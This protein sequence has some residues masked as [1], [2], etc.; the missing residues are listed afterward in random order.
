MKYI[1]HF[2]TALVILI[3]LNTFAQT[4]ANIIIHKT[5]DYSDIPSFFT[6][7]E[8]ISMDQF[9]DWFLENFKTSINYEIIGIENDKQGMIHYRCQ[10]K[11][12]GT[13]LH[14]GIFILHTKNNII[15]SINGNIFSNYSIVNNQ[16]LQESAALNQALQYVDAEIYKWQL[17]EEEKLI[18]YIKDNP[19]A[20][21]YP[22]GE[23]ILIPSTQK[24]TEFILCWE[25]N[26]YAHKPMSRQRIFVNAENG[27]IQNTINCIHDADVPGT[28]N[29]AYNSSQ[30]I[31]ADSYGGSYRLR[32]SGRGLGI[33]TYDMNEGTS[34]PS[35]VDFTDADN[36]WNNYNAQLDQYATD[37]HFAT[38]S[39]YD[40]YYTIHGRNS[41][42]NSGFK[43]ISYIH[44]DVQYVNAFWNGDWM[45]YGDGNSTYS[46][47]TTV[48]ICGHE[49]THGLTS[50]TCDLDYQNESG[51]INE[52]FSDIFGTMVEFFAVPSSAN[53]LIG[54]DIGVAFRS[55]ADPNAY[56]LP[57]TYL[58]NYWAAT[59]TTPNNTNDYGGVHTNCG[60][61]MYWFYL[62][63]EGG[64]GT[65]DNGDSYS[66]TGIGKTK[67]ADIAFRLQTIYLTNS[68]DYSD[69]RTYAIQSAV[70]LY[71]ACTTEV[72]VVTDAMYAVGIGVAYVPTVVSDYTAD[73]TNFCQAPATVIFTN[74]S[75]NASSFIWDFGDGNTST[76]ANPS[77][78]YNNYGDYT[79]KLFADG[80]ACGTDSLINISYVSVQT[81]NPCIYVIGVTT[82]SSE[83]GCTGNLFDSG[84]GSNYQDNTDYSVT[85]QPPG[86]SSVT[87]NF[88][89]FDFESGYD[90]LYIYDGPNSSSSQVAG[91]PFDGTTLPNGGAITSSGGAITIRQTT[92][93]GLTR[94]GFEL[95]WTANYS[96]GTMTPDFTSNVTSSCTGEI[97]FNDSTTHCPIS[98]DWDFGDGNSSN[99]SNP[100]NNY[101]ANGTYTVKLVVSSVSGTDSI[102][103][104]N[105]ITVNMPNAPTATGDQ[106]CELTSLTLTASGSGV[107]NW[108]DQAT[109]GNLLDTGII[110]NTPT[111]S[112]TTIYY[113]EDNIE[114]TPVNGGSNDYNNNGGLYTQANERYLIFNCTSKVILKSVLVNAGASGN[115]TIELQNSSGTTLESTTVNIPTGT[116]RVDLDYIITPGNDYRLVGPASP[117]LYRNSSN[118]NYPYTV[119]NVISITGSN[120]N[121]P[122]A[123][124]YYFYDW[125]VAEFCSSPRIPVTA[126]IAPSPTALFSTS[127]NSYSVS[128]TDLSQDAVSWDWNFG[129]GNT[130][131]QQNPNH[132][133]AT[134]GIY[135]VSLTCTNSCGTNQYFDT[136]NI[137]NVGIDNNNE[138]IVSIYPNPAKDIINI[139]F[140][141][142]SDI[143]YIISLNNVLGQE[144]EVELFIGDGHKAV[145]QK[146]ISSYA[147]GIYVI[148]ILSNHINTNK[149]IIIK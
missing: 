9:N 133:Y 22:K 19:S 143:K 72:G 30:S 115:R 43:L 149:K 129:D 117:N 92:D 113:V 127:I 54:E 90:Y 15:K 17:P 1:K 2:F 5:S 135:Y 112:S 147:K 32:E 53:W 103:K 76:Q 125:E 62:V 16:S 31:T 128:F 25:F 88:T 36:N 84:G 34:Y 63:S 55:L 68:S 18:K 132:T 109:A 146:E 60:V 21:Y 138:N 141:S 122:T 96:T 104:T 44:Y 106:D 93:Q 139:S 51:A 33:E 65:N 14:N 57:D 118:T 11:I 111:L 69:A 3:S 28:A 73:Y 108:Y 119:G 48:D 52:G 35:A 100:T 121:T 4:P 86:A 56:N 95:N 80:G 114:D 74:T 10:Q 140:L 8:E 134:A 75:I 144:L 91:S 87:I 105:Y 137:M 12:Q 130:S 45:T 50:K 97:Q 46:P 148:R 70:D 83:T 123:F 124:Y 82:N 85:I 99:S 89:S 66:I 41:I 6:L 64:S 67:A 59:S 145:I 47:L 37:A 27:E 39:T 102:I 38:E 131:I 23:L 29:T 107:L 81:S 13:P 24:E 49:I 110:Y 77:H 78:T 142:Q 71:G 7:N 26:I 98:W 120:A 20:T 79:V 42:D 58:G 101:T 61:L 94:P 40:Y 116:S 136:L 126:T